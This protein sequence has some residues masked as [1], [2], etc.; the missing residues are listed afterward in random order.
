[1]PKP[2][3][4]QKDETSSNSTSTETVKLTKEVK[5]IRLSRVHSNV[6]SMDCTPPRESDNG[7]KRTTTESVMRNS[8]KRQKIQWP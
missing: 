2:Q 3:R 7:H 4:R 1:M 6:V 8:N 5:R